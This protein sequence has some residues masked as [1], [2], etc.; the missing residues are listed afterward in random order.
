[1][2]SLIPNRVDDPGRLVE[3]SLKTIAQLGVVLYMFLVGLELNT[4]KLG[5]KARAMIAISHSSIVV[6]F[7]LGA[8]LAL[9]LY[10]RFA[11]AGVAF[12]S[13]ALFLGVAMS[14]T[15]FPVLAR[16]LTDRGLERTDLG[17]MA[18]SAAAMGDVTAWCL[19]ALVVGIVQSQVSNALWVAVWSIVF[20]GVIFGVVGPLAKRVA[21]WFERHPHDSVARP[22]L[23]VA[24]LLSALATER[25]GIHAVFGAFLIGVV[26]PPESRLARELGH[27]LQ[28]VVT[29]LLLPAFFA[30]AGMQTQI[31]LISGWQSWLTCGAII[32]VATVGKYGGTLVAARLAGFDWTTSS[33][34]GVLMNTRGLMEL[35]VLNIGLSL[36]VISPTLFAMM[37][38]M[39]L[40][41]TAATAPLFQALV[42]STKEADGADVELAGVVEA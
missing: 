4:A 39:A 1:M 31:G 34:L 18:L 20:V 12:T 23:F 21:N 32:V 42:P 35:I 36:G 3:A 17:L 11:P 41:T 25:I 37:V 38:L 27:Q 10:P 28:A 5:Q 26:I 9:W 13:Y 19:L 16:V 14:I 15:A 29:V 2:H 30:V 33:A 22:G 8:A 6:P 40:A 7:V 24:I